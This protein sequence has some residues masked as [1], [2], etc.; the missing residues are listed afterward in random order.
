LRFPTLRQNRGLR[1]PI[2]ESYSARL[3][4]LIEWE[5]TEKGN[6][7]VLNDTRATTTA[8]STR[9]RMRSFFIECVERTIEVDL[10]AETS[11]GV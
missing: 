2:L 11:L 3:L 8:S 5:P 4:P 10:P 9:R 6:V 7:R 1:R